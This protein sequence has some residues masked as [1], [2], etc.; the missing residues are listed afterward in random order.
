[1]SNQAG[2]PYLNAARN[3]DLAMLK[4]LLQWGCP[5]GGRPLYHKAT[6]LQYETSINLPAVYRWFHDNGFPGDW[7]A[8]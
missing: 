2:E 7:L 1:M 8:A 5:H 4:K 3:G 6:Y